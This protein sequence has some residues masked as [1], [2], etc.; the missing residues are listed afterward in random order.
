MIGQAGLITKSTRPFAICLRYQMDALVASAVRARMSSAITKPL[1]TQV[2][3]P[4]PLLV[5]CHRRSRPSFDQD[6]PRVLL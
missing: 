3:Q 2:S 5:A 6:G 4:S 1:I